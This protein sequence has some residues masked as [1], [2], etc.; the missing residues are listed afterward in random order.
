M[1]EPLNARDMPG[2]LISTQADAHAIR[3]QVGMP[4]LKVQFDLYHAQITEG[5]LTEKLRHWLPHVGH[6]QI[7]GV[8]GAPRAQR[9]RGQ[10]RLPVPSDRRGALGRLDRLRVPAATTTT[11]GLGWMYRLIDRQRAPA[12]A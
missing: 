1:I 3:E 2:Y 12:K 5:D 11:A 8:P 9:R 10:L 7:A 6:I 4:N